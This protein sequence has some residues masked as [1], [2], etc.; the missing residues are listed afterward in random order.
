[1]SY[2]RKFRERVLAHVDAGK[3]QEEVRDMFGLGANTISQ[4]KKLRAETGKLEKRELKRKPKKIDPEKL[5]R[6][7]TEKPDDFDEERAV[8][9]NCTGEAI[10]QVRK[11]LKITRKKR[12]Y[13]T[14]ENSNVSLCETLNFR[15]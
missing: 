3:K 12:H 11:K 5:K 9:F 15:A 8:R 13:I 2:D 6:D 10:R 4:W 14:P 7:I 1:M